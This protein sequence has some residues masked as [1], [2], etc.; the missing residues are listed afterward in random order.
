M[1]PLED[2]LARQREDRKREAAKREVAR[3]AEA[4]AAPVSRASREEA[5]QTFRELRGHVAPPQRTARASASA[6][7]TPFYYYAGGEF[8]TLNLHHD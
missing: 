2:R 1:E 4:G 3:K 7:S 6:N 8:R 5:R